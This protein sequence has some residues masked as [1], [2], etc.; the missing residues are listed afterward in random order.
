MKTLQI[1]V[2][3]PLFS[4]PPSILTPHLKM[5]FFI[6]PSGDFEDPLSP[7]LKEG[8]RTL[9]L[10][11][12]NKIR[13]VF[14]ALKSTS[15]FLPQFTVSCRSDSSSEVNSSCCHRSDAWS[16]LVQRIVSSVKTSHP[17]QGKTKYLTWNSTR[18][19]YE[20]GQPG[21]NTGHFWDR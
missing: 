4:I 3:P 10:Y 19:I 6:P 11:Q 2:T 9:W 8:G 7:Q 21:G 1:I 20:E 16:H 12:S 17:E 14:P 5:K 13:W 15:H 18:L